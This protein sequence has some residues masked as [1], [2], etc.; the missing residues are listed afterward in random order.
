MVIKSRDFS[1]SFIRKPT[2]ATPDINAGN[3]E[4]LEEA[5]LFARGDTPH[6]WPKPKR[7][8]GPCSLRRDNELI[9]PL[10]EQRTL[11]ASRLNRGTER[12]V[13]V[14]CIN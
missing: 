9:R 14:V 12:S 5:V 2:L 11:V 1:E 7:V 10:R 6:P 13:K 4:V 8:Y 3:L